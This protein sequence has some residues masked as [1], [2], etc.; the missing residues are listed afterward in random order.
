[1][2]NSRVI[3]IDSNRS[4]T[5]LNTVT[6][7]PRLLGVRSSLTGRVS[8]ERFNDDLLDSVARPV[9]VLG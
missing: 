9:R 6:Q 1:M 8:A 7:H 4:T 2:N 3:L 5:N